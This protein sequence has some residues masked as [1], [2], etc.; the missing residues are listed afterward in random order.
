MTPKEL[1]DWAV[2]NGAE[3]Y[4]LWVCTFQNGQGEVR[5]YLD[6]QYT[7]KDDERERIIFDI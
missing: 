3:D 2:N 1:Y 6:E 7:D 5:N 4:E